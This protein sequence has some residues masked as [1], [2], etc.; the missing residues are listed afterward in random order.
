MSICTITYWCYMGKVN[1][2]V[3]YCLINEKIEYNIKGILQ[4]QKLKFYDLKSTMVLDLKLNTLE[5]KLDDSVILFDF[6]QKECIIL[7]KSNNQQI[8]FFIEVLELKN[9]KSEFFVKYKF[10]NNYFEILIKII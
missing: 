10:D 9:E 4:N 8:K 1:L 2:L 3:K 6:L 7:D 5:R